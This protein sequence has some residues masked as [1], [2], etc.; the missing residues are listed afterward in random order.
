MEEVLLNW[1]V[2]K[3]VVICLGGVFSM[4]MLNMVGAMLVLIW[5]NPSDRLL[6]T[7]LGFAAGVML[8]ASFTSLILPGIAIG[9]IWPVMIGM[10]LGVFTLDLVDR[11]LPHVHSQTGREGPKSS[12]L[13]GVWLLIIA[14]TLR[15]MP[16]GLVVGGEVSAE[17]Q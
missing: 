1:V 6:N 3:P 14:F 5:R 9:G 11:R 10:G 12:R 13:G 15:N 8:T 17:A 16:E 7:A 2:D 4:A